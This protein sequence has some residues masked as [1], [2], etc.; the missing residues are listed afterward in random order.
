M[1]DVEAVNNGN[2]T[3]EKRKMDNYRKKLSDFMALGG[4]VKYIH[5]LDEID[6]EMETIK[7][8]KKMGCLHRQ[9]EFIALGLYLT[10]SQLERNAR[11]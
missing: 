5:D 3:P 9:E 10:Q 6:N 2:I 1:S 7:Y 4:Q 11:W 8:L